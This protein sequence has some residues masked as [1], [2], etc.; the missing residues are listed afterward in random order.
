MPGRFNSLHV[1]TRQ[2]YQV[3]G[4]ANFKPVLTA[5]THSRSRAIRRYGVLSP[6][7]HVM[8]PPTRMAHR[9]VTAVNGPG[10]GCGHD[11]HFAFP[12]FRSMQV[13]LD[14]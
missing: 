1:R 12:S 14:L 7:Q 9:V 6:S 10:G 4:G 3:R 5:R 13:L 2:Q 11:A 8:A